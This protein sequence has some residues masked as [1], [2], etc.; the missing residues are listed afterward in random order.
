MLLP[1]ATLLILKVSQCR[2]PHIFGK[3]AKTAYLASKKLKVKFQ[4]RRERQPLNSPRASAQTRTEQ[5]MY[6]YPRRQ[7]SI[8]AKEHHYAKSF[9]AQSQSTHQLLAG[10]Y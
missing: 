6:P 10:N 7:R 2:E 8:P 1:Y 9:P 5:K 4:E 3:R